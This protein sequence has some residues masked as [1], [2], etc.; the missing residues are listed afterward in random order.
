MIP[1]LLVNF[2]PAER[3]EILL[4]SSIPRTFDLLLE[5]LGQGRFHVHCTD[6]F[7]G[8]RLLFSRQPPGLMVG[9]TRTGRNQSANYHVFFQTTEKIPFASNRRLGQHA[10]RFLE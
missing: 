3:L 2:Y 4:F 1:P 6:S 9:K 10:S 5:R 8:L 7:P